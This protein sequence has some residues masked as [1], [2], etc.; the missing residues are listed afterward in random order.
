MNNPVYAKLTSIILA[1]LVLSSVLL[2]CGGKGDTPAQNGSADTQTD[3][4]TIEETTA[5]ATSVPVGT[6]FGG[7]TLNVMNYT[8]E[9]FYFDV[10]E[11]TGDVVNDAVYERNMKVQNDVNVSFNILTKDGDAASLIEKSVTSG[12]NDYDFIFGIQ[13]EFVPLV[14][15]GMFMNLEGAPYIDIEKDWWDKDYIH[16]CS[17]GR[18]KRFFISGD[19]TLGLIRH[20][21][22]CYVN[23]QMFENILG[24]PQSIYTTVLDGKWTLDLF[25]EY[26][27][28]CYS[29]LNGDSKFDEGDQYGCGVITLNLTD[30]FTYD[31]GVRCTE[32]D[33]NDIP[34]LVMNNERTVSYAEKIKKIYYENEGI[35]IFSADYTS[36]HETIPNK[37]KN[38]S[39]AFMVGWFYISDYLRDMEGDYAVI[40]FPKFDE[41]QENYLAL[42]HDVATLVCVPT[43]CDKLDTVAAVLELLAYEGYNTVAPAYY[44]VAL[45]TKYIRDNQDE[46]MQIMDIIHDA[47]TSDFAYIYNYALNGIGLIMRDVL[48][49]K[50]GNFASTYAKKEV[51][52]Q[53]L[54]DELIEVYTSLD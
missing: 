5:P 40:P 52:T 23:K 24:D 3:A 21:S 30:H 41:T 20:Q 19:I 45:K 9:N 39:L 32:R 8:M 35:R 51:K 33:E 47:S 37:F 31:A 2:A 10:A 6:D 38:N 42:I 18:N 54:L 15:K 46:A 1:A 7:T 17:I 43:T 22:C 53:K 50:K 13:Y 44:E 14:L 26:A 48:G 49:S 29:D 27:S 16:E 34:I 36:L 25:S 12:S 11:E 28:K 4:E